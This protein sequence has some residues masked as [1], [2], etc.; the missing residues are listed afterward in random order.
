M[1]AVVCFFISMV[2]D[3]LQL[4][5]K[6]NEELWAWNPLVSLGCLQNKNQINKFTKNKYI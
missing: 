4:D 2:V 5:D 3:E 1:C 6:N